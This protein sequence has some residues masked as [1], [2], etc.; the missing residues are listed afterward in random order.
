MAINQSINLILCQYLSIFNLI[1][2]GVYLVTFKHLPILNL[3]ILICVNIS[4]KSTI[5]LL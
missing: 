5:Q 3:Y 4:D 1:G 2:Q